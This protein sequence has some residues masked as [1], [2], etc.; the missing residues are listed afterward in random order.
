M[1]MKVVET[2]DDA[3]KLVRQWKEA[4]SVVG[5]VPTMGY[6]HQGH[7]SLME[8]CK[9]RADR[10]MVSLF[11]NPTQFSPSEDLD[12]YPRDL[13]R[14]KAL[15]ERCGVDAIFIPGEEEMYLPGHRTWVTVQGLSEGLCGR[16]RPTHFRGVATVVAKLFNI[17]LPDVAVFGEKDFQQLQIIRQMVRDLDMPVEI[18]G[19][20]IVR[21]P[22]GLA[23]SSRNAYLNEEERRSAV[24]LFQALELATRLVQEGVESCGAIQQALRQKIE[25]FPFTKIDY[26]FT[27]DP[28]TLE[29]VERVKR[30]LLVALAVFV[31]STRLIDNTVI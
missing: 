20:P 7:L 15:A 17:I 11:V 19:C 12:S 23:M 6:F 2:K 18:I 4:S 8:E 25:S 26:I 14:D 21:E 28:Q 31:G 5:L 3:R 30:P 10:V 13:E 24:C 1:Q 22:D 16:S 27:G 9:R 29:P